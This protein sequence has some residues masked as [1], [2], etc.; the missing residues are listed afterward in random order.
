MTA[1]TPDVRLRPVV[2]AD[3]EFLAVLYAST[4]EEELAPL[5]WPAEQK[6]AFLAQQFAAQS[7]HYAK[8]YAGAS[9][10]L[11]LVDGEP[12]GRL[13]VARR[14]GAIRIVDIALMPAHR[15][16]GIG[17]GLLRPLLEEGDATGA[18]VSIHVERSNPARRLYE[19]LGFLVVAGEGAYLRM[20]R[21]PGGDQEKT[22]S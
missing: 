11:V 21:P 12:A 9:F 20:E 2:L 7:A 14:E 22:A 15:R 17:T 19:R 3:E 18:V 1:E 16:R 6:R 4:R 5:P 10:Q 13:I 8:H